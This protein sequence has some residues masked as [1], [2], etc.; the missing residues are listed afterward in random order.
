MLKQ[1]E[2]GIVLDHTFELIVASNATGL[3]YV[4]DTISG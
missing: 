2:T 1:H 3:T 4:F